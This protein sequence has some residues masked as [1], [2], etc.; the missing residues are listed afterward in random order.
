MLVHSYT[1]DIW[2]SARLTYHSTGVDT[3]L[4]NAYVSFFQ[5]YNVLDPENRASSCLQDRQCSSNLLSMRV[6]ENCVA[7]VSSPNE[8]APVCETKGDLVN[9]L[10]ERNILQDDIQ[11][12]SDTTVC[13][14]VL[15][16]DSDISSYCTSDVDISSYCTSDVSSGDESVNSFNGQWHLLLLDIQEQRDR[17]KKYAHGNG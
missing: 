11:F 7:G 10:Y 1:C 3:E 16:S 9:L 4:T 12:S 6:A 15:N 13:D 8:N 17:R 14:S 2:S 5:K